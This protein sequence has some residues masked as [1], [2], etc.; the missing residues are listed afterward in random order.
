MPAGV[1]STSSI[2][3]SEFIRA[4]ITR[5]EFH[6]VLS[7]V[8]VVGVILV[9]LRNVRATLVTALIL[10]TSVLGTFAVM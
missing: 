6:L 9:F 2:D 4:S 5:G 7:I 10:P 3:R 8:L 1:R